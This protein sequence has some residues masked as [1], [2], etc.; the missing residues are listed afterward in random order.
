MQV[1]LHKAG[2]EDPTDVGLNYTQPRPKSA[3][4]KEDLVS[5]GSRSST[6]EPAAGDRSPT[7]AS[8]EG[9]PEGT[10]QRGAGRLESLTRRWPGLT[11]LR[12]VRHLP[13]RCTQP[14]RS[15]SR[16]EAGSAPAGSQ[17]NPFTARCSG[18]SSSGLSCTGRDRFG[19]GQVAARNLF[20]AKAAA[21]LVQ[22]QLGRCT[23][24]LRSTGCGDGSSG[25]CCNDAAAGK[26]TT[27]SRQLPHTQLCRYKR[28]KLKHVKVIKN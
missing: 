5:A 8:P 20:A 22:H 26:T 10:F 17:C 3:S 28:L 2:E 19:T 24:P 16:G 14:L 9:G 11:G 1:P 12:Q 13:G 6:A 7:A 25:L 21:K 4:E 15:K 18:D 27:R 23:Q